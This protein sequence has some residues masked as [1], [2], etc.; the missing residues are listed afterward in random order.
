MASTGIYA[1]EI[2]DTRTNVA[3]SILRELINNAEEMRLRSSTPMTG[4]REEGYLARFCL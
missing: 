2:M 4:L 3:K 1:P